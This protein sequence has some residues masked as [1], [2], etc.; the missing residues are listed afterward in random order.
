MWGIHIYV[1]NT[2]RQQKTRRR[3]HTVHTY[4]TFLLILLALD[5]KLMNKEIGTLMFLLELY[6]YRYTNR[7]MT[8]C[9]LCKLYIYRVVLSISRL[10]CV[11]MKNTC[12]GT[13]Y[14]YLY[15]TVTKVHHVIYIVYNMY[16]FGPVRFSA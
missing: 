2:R 1:S 3:T 12:I 13:V 14:S 9:D 10:S 16:R 4:Y 5:R 7:I 15:F 6:I 8:L 11:R